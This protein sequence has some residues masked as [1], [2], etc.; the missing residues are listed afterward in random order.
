[1]ANPSLSVTRLL[2]VNEDDQLRQALTHR[3]QR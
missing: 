1:M 3:F 2:V